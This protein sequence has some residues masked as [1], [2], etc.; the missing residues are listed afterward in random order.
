MVTPAIVDNA[1]AN[2]KIPG[3]DAF[4]LMIFDECHHT[5]GEHAYNKIMSKYLDAKLKKRDVR[6][7]LPQ[8]ICIEKYHHICGSLVHV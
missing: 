4:T 7:K 3:F 2:G 8:V 1:L 5:D 6:P